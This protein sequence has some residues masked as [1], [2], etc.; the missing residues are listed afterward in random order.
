MNLT[1]LQLKRNSNLNPYPVLLTIRSAYKIF[2]LRHLNT[3]IK[4]YYIHI[5]QS[6]SI[7]LKFDNIIYEIDDLINTL[8]DF[9]PFHISS[10][11]DHQYTSNQKQI[12]EKFVSLL[13]NLA[14]LVNELKMVQQ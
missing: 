3:I 9:P 2:S 5:I 8:H 10:Q 12:R 4:E 7:K 1:S 14:Q 13:E 11:Q 6:R